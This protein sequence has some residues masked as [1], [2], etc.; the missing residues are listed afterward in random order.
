MATDG[1]FDPKSNK[2]AGWGVIV[3]SPSGLIRMFSGAT[4]FD[5]TCVD[6]QGEDGPHEQHWGAES[7]AGCTLVQAEAPGRS[8]LA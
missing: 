3:I 2:P 4:E 7:D 1:S 8:E 6:W 5:Q